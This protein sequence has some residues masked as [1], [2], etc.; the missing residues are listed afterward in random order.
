MAALPSSPAPAPEETVANSLLS[1]RVFD[2]QIRLW[3]VESQRRLLSSHVL[4]VGLTSIHV[5]L[6]KNLALS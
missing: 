4:L 6:A 2:R 3:G 1:H 5:E